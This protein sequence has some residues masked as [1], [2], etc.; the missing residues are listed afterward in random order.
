VTLLRRILRAARAQP[1]VTIAAIVVLLGSAV[2][3]AAVVVATGDDGEATLPPVTTTAA[4]STTL[5]PTTTVAPTTT[6]TTSTTTTVAPTTTTAPTTTAPITTV[7]Q[8]QRCLVRLHGKGGG[9]ADTYT[10]GG[11]KVL[12]PGGNADGWSGRQWLYFP[13]GRYNEV[14]KIVRDAIDDEDCGAVI[15]NGF[16]NGAALAAKFYCRGE[17][18]DGRVVGYVVDDPVVD[19][20]VEGC[21]PANGVD[22]TLYWT[23]FLAST[24]YPG[25]NCAEQDWTCEGGHTIGIDAYASEMGTAAKQSKYS[26]HRWYQDAPE[27]NAW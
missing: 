1:G 15:V 2:A 24:A 9:G 26:D 21:Q 6:S 27:L 20:A 19:E 12:T 17:T 18:F 3:S 23:G 11:V 7:P 22:V 25:W 5:P 10:A 13:N 14:R 4:P 8:G 16:S